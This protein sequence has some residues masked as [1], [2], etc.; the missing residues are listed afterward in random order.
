MPRFG[1]LSDVGV[2]IESV[3]ESGSRF[4]C[5]GDRR[6]VRAVEAWSSNSWN[7]GLGSRVNG[8]LCGFNTLG[9]VPGPEKHPVEKRGESTLCWGACDPSPAAKGDGILVEGGPTIVDLSGRQG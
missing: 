1:V 4:R 8:P 6:M 3:S 9:T 7:T 5:A 2:G